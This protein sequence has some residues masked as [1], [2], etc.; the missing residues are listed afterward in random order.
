MA[1]ELRFDV[2]VGR[3]VRH[4]RASGDRPGMRI[5]LL[6]DFTGY[7]TR[8]R[9]PLGERRPESVDVDNFE[10][11]FRRW[12]PSVL[13]PADDGATTHT[14]VELRDLDGF[15]PDSLVERVPA[16]AALRQVR[17]RL[18]DA[19]TSAATVAELRRVT[20]DPLP[21]T[22]DAAAQESDPALLDRLLGRRSAPAAP[23]PTAAISALIQRLVEPHIVPAVD[24]Q[25]SHFVA[26]IDHTLT[27]HMRRLLHHPDFQALESAW[28]A[29]HW[30]ISNLETSDDLRIHLLDVTK[31]ELATAFAGAT[32][33]EESTLHRLLTQAGAS[34]D[35]EVAWSVL[36]GGFR[37]GPTSE[38]V[39]LLGALGALGA[40][41]GAPFLAE[42]NTAL[43]GCSSLAQMPDPRQWAP[44]DAATA[45][46]WSVLRRSAAAPWLGLALPRIMLR[47]PYGRTTDP[48][49]QFPFEEMPSPPLHEAY[50]WGSPAF[51]CALLLG[52]A[53]T[54]AG[55]A[56]T[57]GDRQ[58][59]LDLPSH[60]YVDGGT[61]ALTPSSEVAVSERTAETILARGLM[62]MVS[63]A[64]R[65][66][67]RVARFQSLADPP[68]TLSGAWS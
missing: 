23:T 62:P 19:N 47:A 11:L 5:L 27:T 1:G 8:P 16:V 29:A 67:V 39:E 56:M 60:S 2:R 14:L 35:G 48:I 59:L 3:P 7:G 13:L 49:E 6:A 55:P 61:P 22:V 52:Q 68:A 64:Q 31:Q 38:D 45:E 4:R 65:N 43:I 66:L 25:A 50:L 33:I 30:V 37:F 36:A 12:A 44:L 9:P 58:D 41:I 34:D 10:D 21:A 46:R 28:R 15:H 57:P 54:D 20:A 18:L 63:F 17:G 32:T 53:Y 51:A 42:A 26:A 40:S 24:P